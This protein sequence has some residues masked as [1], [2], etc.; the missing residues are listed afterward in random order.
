M[1]LL[2]KNDTDIKKPCIVQ[3]LSISALR[4]NINSIHITL[5]VIVTY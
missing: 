4:P 3:V 5:V 2:K 1:C